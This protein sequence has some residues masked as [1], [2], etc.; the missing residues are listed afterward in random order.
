[1]EAEEQEEEEGDMEAEEQEEEE[2]GGGEC[3]TRY[4]WNYI[5]SLLHTHACYYLAARSLSIKIKAD[6][7]YQVLLDL[8]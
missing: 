5:Q 4:F 2:E 7:S 6:D 8:F 1:M 3:Y